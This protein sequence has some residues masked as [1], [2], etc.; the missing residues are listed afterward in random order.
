MLMTGAW[1]TSRKHTLRSLIWSTSNA[2]MNI[3]T[4]LCMY[5][6]GQHVQ[7]TPGGVAAASNNTA[8]LAIGVS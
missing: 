6:I 4:G 5:A 7:R 2:G 8:L 1:Y 3:I